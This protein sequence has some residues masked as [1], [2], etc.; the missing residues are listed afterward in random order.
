V[1]TCPELGT[2]A[3]P[4]H[5]RNNGPPSAAFRLVN[6]VGIA[7][8]RVFGAEPSRPASLLC[9][10]RTHQSPGECA[11]L[12]TGLPARL[13]PGGTFTRWTPSRSFTVSSSVPPLPDFSQRDNNVAPVKHF[14]RRTTPSALKSAPFRSHWKITGHHQPK[15]RV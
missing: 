2:P 11:T 10:L 5:P 8:S 14:L 13:W 6:N 1:E 9:T 4:A 7:T 3:T 15:A 12:A